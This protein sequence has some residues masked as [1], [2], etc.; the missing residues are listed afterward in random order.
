VRVADIDSKLAAQVAE[1]GRLRALILELWQR[2]RMDWGFVTDRLSTTFR[3]E[4]WVGARERRFVGETLFGLV[5]H[6]RRI[7]FALERGATS[8][9]RRTPR[10]LE[11]LLALLV[12]DKRVEPDVAARVMR[13]EGGANVDW[14]RVAAI[15][16]EIDAERDLATRIGL[17][18]SLPDWL[19]ARLIGDWGP[20]AEPLALAL[21]QRA[22]MTVRANLLVGDRD[23]LAAELGA[24]GFATTPGAH[25]DTALTIDTRT[26]L[27]ATSAFKRGAMEAQDQGSQLLAD[28]AIASARTDKPLIV[29]LCAGA[30]GKTLAMAARLRNRGRIVATDIDAGKLDELRK[31]ARRAT[32]SNTRALHLPDGRWPPEL[33][34]IRGKADLV[35]VDAPC[36]GIGSLRRNPEA[37][38]R[39]R[40][41]DLV[42]FANR[43][44]SI[45]HDALALLG[46]GGRVV[47]A[48]CT[49]LRTE[50]RDVVDAACAGTPEIMRVPVGTVLGERASGFD[51]GGDF[52]TAPDTHDTDGF[53]AAIAERASSVQ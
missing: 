40:E 23:A 50:N 38:W 4:S 39:L 10:D 12:I 45:L 35:L 47:Y 33:D 16:D 15:D 27:F 44:R 41:A 48:T 26:N 42:E 6:L 30:G 18:A 22:P 36:S 13:R 20:R 19:V 53:F 29:D 1:G 43:Q 5:R 9:A 28:L 7:D 46:P 21:N 8:K 32:V 25:C 17:A 2:T 3:K 52:V 31:R 14:S 11:R 37:R 34:A 51:E 24:A 49:L